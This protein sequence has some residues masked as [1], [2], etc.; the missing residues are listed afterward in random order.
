M[1][2]KEPTAEEYYQKM[3]DEIHEALCANHMNSAVADFL[4]DLAIRVR[5]LERFES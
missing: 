5:K 1:A 2:E 4:T 3:S